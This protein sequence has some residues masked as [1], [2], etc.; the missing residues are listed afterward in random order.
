M[1]RVL[2]LGPDRQRSAG[3]RSL[4]ARDGHDVTWLKSL[5]AWRNHEREILPHVVVAAV[6]ET[7]GVVGKEAARRAAGFRPPLL[8]VQ[9]EADFLCEPD[10]EG[11]FVD[12]LA[13]PFMSDELLARVDALVR[14][15]QI[16][17]GSHRA[18]AP[19]G[20]TVR[21][22]FSS[23]LRARLPEQE[24]PAA[25][26]LEVA[27]R[28]AEWADRR[29]AFTPGH[30]ERVTIFC[31]MIS[32]GLAMGERETGALLRAAMLHDIGKVGLPVEMLHQQAP[33]NEGQRRLIR[34]HPSRGATLLRAL[35]P[36]E[37]IARAVLYHHERP[38]GTG[39]F[40]KA[41]G[42]VPRTARALA[43]AETYDAMTKSLLGKTVDAETALDILAS[44]KGQTYDADCVEALED[45]L[46][47]RCTSIPLST[48]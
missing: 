48:I 9:Q 16:V 29:D 24:R 7:D 34:T 33:L 1:A 13:S 32:E 35:D 22:R 38:D 28:I 44:G 46:K 19:A 31:G 12:R 3:L 26:Y 10:L 30:A 23:W 39:Y 27:A 21:R 4:F 8:F 41:A 20:T 15:H 47:P 45:A 14:V 17:G 18:G 36:D 42:G 5:H 43:V 6:G 40:G 2:L 37:G 25:P 11:R